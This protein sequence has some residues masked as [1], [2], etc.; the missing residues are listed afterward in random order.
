MTEL[1]LTDENLLKFLKNIRKED[2]DE[3]KYFF[4]ENLEENFIK[5]CKENSKTYFL[6]DD[7]LNP[8]AIGGVKRIESE[9]NLAGQVWFLCTDKFY[10]S[11][12]AVFKF[13][14]RKIENFKKEYDFLFNFIYKSNFETLKW[15]L[16]CGFSAEHI[17]NDFKLF[18]FGKGDNKLDLR[19]FT[20]E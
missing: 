9:G 12:I 7:C 18:Y 5:I 11:K 17:N 10:S 15:L 1:E 20:R 3:L 2:L 4:K 16:R 19:Y 8:L 14:R 13:I 6:A